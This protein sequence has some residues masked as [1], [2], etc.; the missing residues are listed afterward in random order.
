MKKEKMNKLKHRAKNEYRMTL[1]QCEQDGWFE[2]T[3]DITIGTSTLRRKTL[4][5]IEWLMDT[6]YNFYEPHLAHMFNNE[7]HRHHY[8]LEMRRKK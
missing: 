5:E 4:Q 8:W 2:L 6:M 7:K 1:I 3:S